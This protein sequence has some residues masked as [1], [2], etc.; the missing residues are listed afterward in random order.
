MEDRQDTLRIYSNH[1]DTLLRTLGLYGKAKGGA[2]KIKARKVAGN[3]WAGKLSITDFYLSEAPFL[4]QLLSLASPFGLFDIVSD[5]GLFF[6]RLRTQFKVTPTRIILT[7]GHAAGM[8]LGLTVS[9]SYDRKTQQVHLHGS[10]VPA[11]IFTSLLGSIPLVGELFGGPGGVLGVS[12][13][14]DGDVRQP[15]MN[16]NPLSAFAPGILRRLFDPEDPLNR[17]DEEEK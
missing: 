2:L 1:A 11:Y 16:I 10:I 9:G 6:D 17:E 4:T 14:V 15:K 5:K 7:E 12:Y 3:A 13:S 8:S